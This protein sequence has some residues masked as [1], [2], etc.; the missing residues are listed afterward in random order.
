MNS[1]SRTSPGVG[2]GICLVVVDDFD[3]VGTS[4]VQTKQMRHCRLIP[5]YLATHS[6]LVPRAVLRSESPV[7]LLLFITHML[8]G[9]SLRTS[10]YLR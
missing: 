9:N 7:G 1:S 3:T 6:R 4:V 8:I 5:K 2:F 10:A